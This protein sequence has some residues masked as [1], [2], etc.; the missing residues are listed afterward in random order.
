MAFSSQSNGNIINFDDATSGNH[1]YRS[2][3]I[4]SKAPSTSTSTDFTSPLFDSNDDTF[5]AIGGAY[6]LN[7]T[8]DH[9]EP[10]QSLSSAKELSLSSAHSAGVGHSAGSHHGGAFDS[11]MS[12]W[13][14][15][16]PMNNSNNKSFAGLSSA[17]MVA[18]EHDDCPSVPV[19]V[20]QYTTFTVA[21][22]SVFD[23]I[24]AHLATMGIDHSVHDHKLRGLVYP[25]DRAGACEFRVYRYKCAAA[26]EWLIE[27]QRRSGCIFA[28]NQL[29]RSIVA[30]TSSSHVHSDGDHQSL[31][32]SL[33]PLSSLTISGSSAAA[34]PTSA[35]M[36]TVEPLTV[37]QLSTMAAS[38]AVEVAHE[39]VE[40]L[41][42]LSSMSVAHA[43]AVVSAI[44]ALSLPVSLITI[45]ATMVATA[46]APTARAAADLIANL[47]SSSADGVQM[48]LSCPTLVSSLFTMLDA[49]S[50]LSLR[51]IKRHCARA[52]ASLASSD[53]N[54][55]RK[56]TAAY[57]GLPTSAFPCVTILERYSAVDD[58]ALR[59]SVVNALALLR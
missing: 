47:V 2:V 43:A 35:L 44:K 21:R 1:V 9:L 53:I 52:I 19:Y 40:A 20:E 41:A 5:R 3:Q 29:Y 57:D 37:K 54:A 22:R 36:A 7:D 25:A 27:V 38:S 30:C 15:T 56:A 42:V 48:A 49:P 33:P 12:S 58:V 4:E 14:Y 45:A 17:Q 10:V 50:S 31:V 23:D 55:L 13:P 8:S 6:T 32:S 51:D 18:H 24:A 26:G 34:E 16:A 28:F 11:L 39:G 59:T 46:R